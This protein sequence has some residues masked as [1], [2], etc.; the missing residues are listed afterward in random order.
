MY[1]YSKKFYVYMILYINMMAM[2]GEAAS[3]FFM[4]VFEW[5]YLHKK[6]GFLHLAKVLSFHNDP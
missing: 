2:H 3:T 6:G 1:I 5:L 4:F